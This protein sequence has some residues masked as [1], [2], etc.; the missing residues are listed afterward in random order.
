[1]GG[2]TL[3]PP[4]DATLHQQGDLAAQAALLLRKPIRLQQNKRLLLP[5]GIYESTT[6]K[7]CH[8]PFA[9]ALLGKYT[10]ETSAAMQIKLAIYKARPVLPSVIANSHFHTQLQAVFWFAVSRKH[11]PSPCCVYVQVATN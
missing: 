6:C 11:T 8:D 9:N 4:K 3:W 2:Q 10:Q 5:C 7:H 1:M